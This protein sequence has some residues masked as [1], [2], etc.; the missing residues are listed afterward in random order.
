MSELEKEPINTMNQ[1]RQLA[2]QAWCQETT[3]SIEMDARLAEAF[4]AILDVKLARL[5]ALEKRIAEAPESY[6]AIK[7]GRVIGF[8]QDD[9]KEGGVWKR[10]WLLPVEEEW[11]Q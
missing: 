1:A 6:I 8:N 7:H 11:K 9:M 10:V 2:A 5:A 3:S 4:A